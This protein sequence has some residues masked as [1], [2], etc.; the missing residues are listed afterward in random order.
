MQ[1]QAQQPPAFIN[2]DV[3]ALGMPQLSS[4]SKQY[5]CNLASEKVS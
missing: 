4:A 1:V 3:E 5:F 2:V